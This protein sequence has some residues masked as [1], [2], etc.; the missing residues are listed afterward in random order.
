MTSWKSFERR[1]AVWFGGRRRGCVTSSVTGTGLSD[2]VDTPGFSVEC[3]LLGRPGYADLLNAALQAERN[4][5]PHELP[6]AVVKKKHAED[7]DS[8]CILRLETFSAWFLPPQVRLGE[9]KSIEEDRDQGARV[10]DP[11]SAD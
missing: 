3:K 2:L 5:E 10:E 11:P 1:I 4:A 7:R 9:E 8:L 6:V